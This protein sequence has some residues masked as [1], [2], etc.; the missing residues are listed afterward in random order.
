MD[1]GIGLP[2]AI[3]DVDGESL[4]EFAKR[5]DARGFSSLGTVDRIVYPNFEPVLSLAAA[6]MVTDRI[7]LAT[8][9][10]LG[11]LRP[12]AVLLA[13]ELATL[14]NLSGGRFWLGIGLGA[15][16]D[17]Y[18]LSGIPTKGR[19]AALDRQLEQI[20]QVWDGDEVGPAVTTPGGP[21]I[22]VGGSADATFERAAKFGAGWIMGGGT[23]E[24]FAD[25]SKKVDQAWDR[26]GRSDKP[27]KAALAYFSLGP[28]AQAHAERNIGH[29]YA[30]LGEIGDM[31]VASAATSPEMVKSYVEGFEQAGC[32]EVILFPG[33]KHPEQVDLLADAVG[34]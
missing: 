11:P 31:I 10:L 25:S 7:R 6:A 32:D 26:A 13:K 4:L 20:K 17:D 28:D 9:V 8:T 34:K 3:Q 16:E 14:D 5:A 19:G 2:N 24:M 22:I 30:W 18:Q 29:Y 15:R 12:N 27:R 1:I 33:S 23:P 21:R